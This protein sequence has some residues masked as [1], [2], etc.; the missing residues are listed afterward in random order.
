MA[1]ARLGTPSTPTN[2]WHRRTGCRPA[3]AL[4]AVGGKGLFSKPPAMAGEVAAAT[5]ASSE[6]PFGYARGQGELT[7]DFMG[8]C[9][10]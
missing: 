10:Q 7:E 4:R 2:R 1:S 9:L 5:K 8:L 3:L 6:Q